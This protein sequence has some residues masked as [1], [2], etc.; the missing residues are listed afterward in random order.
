MEELKNNSAPPIQMDQNNDNFFLFDS[1]ILNQ[2][3][4]NEFNPNDN[5]YQNY[6]KDNQQNIININN[7][8]NRNNKLFNNYDINEKYKTRISIKT[9][10]LEELDKKYLIELIQFII[11]SCN[12]ILED[13]RYIDSTYSIFKIN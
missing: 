12:L 4:I 3:K 6:N 13:Y 10:E 11:Y 5:Q 1:T 8:N 7:I 2:N 9:K